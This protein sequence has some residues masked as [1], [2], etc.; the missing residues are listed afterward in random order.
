M[1]NSAAVTDGGRLTRRMLA[2]KAAERRRGGEV[3]ISQA[4]VFLETFKKKHGDVEVFMDCPKCQG[5]FKL[6]YVA[7]VPVTAHLQERSGEPNV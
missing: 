7:N 5:A 4:I 3:T 6:D 1:K 2:S